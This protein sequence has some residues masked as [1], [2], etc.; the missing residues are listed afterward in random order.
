MKELLE[1]IVKNLVDDKDDAVVSLT[2]N[3]DVTEIVISV[4]ENDI[5]KVIGRQGKVISS[6]R[7]LVKSIGIKNGIKYNVEIAG[8]EK[9]SVKRSRD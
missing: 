4:A 3:D 8:G 2:T 6:I 9:K 5:G 7:T 1:Y